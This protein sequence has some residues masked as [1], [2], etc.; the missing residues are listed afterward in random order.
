[1]ISLSVSIILL[2]VST[3][4]FSIR[5]REG[6]VEKQGS[7]FAENGFLLLF[8]CKNSSISSLLSEFSDAFSCLSAPDSLYFVY[9]LVC[10]PDCFYVGC[11]GMIT[12]F[13]SMDKGL[14][15][16]EIAL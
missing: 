3:F 12:A 1:M 11:D 15:F 9:Q 8:P 16:V 4:Y 5:R 14:Y 6:K 13:H 7:F 10:S 2:L